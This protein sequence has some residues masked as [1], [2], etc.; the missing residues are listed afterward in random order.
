M[1]TPTQHF[2]SHFGLTFL[3]LLAA[4][5]W[6]AG[7]AGI[8]GHSDPLAG[9][10]VDVLYQPDQAIIDDYLGY[11]H[12]LPSKDRNTVCSPSFLVDGAGRHAIDVE[13]IIAGKNASWHYAFIYDSN[14]KRISVTK[15]GYTRYQQG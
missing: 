1:K 11:I 15:F 4:L 3:V 8:V 14:N 9:W 6:A 12:N 2:I 5:F 7:C 10:K 13:I